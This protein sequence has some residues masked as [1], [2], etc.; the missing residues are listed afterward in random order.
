MKHKIRKTATILIGC[1]LI[2]G[3]GTA[4]SASSGETAP[5]LSLNED[6]AVAE[7]IGLWERGRDEST[8]LSGEISRGQF[9]KLVVQALDLA[10]RR[11]FP[12]DRPFSDVSGDSLE[13]WFINRAYKEGLVSGY[14]DGTFRPERP[15]L[16]QE[17]AVI[18]AKA[19]SLPGKEAEFS[20]VS[21]NTVF[22]PFIGAVT[23][24]GVLE[25]ESPGR[26]GF[27]KTVTG[28]QAVILA[29]RVYNA[30]PFELMEATIPQMQAAMETGKL[31]SEQLVKMYLD[32]IAAYDQQ[33]PK[34]N[35]MLA[36]N[37]HALETARQLD[38]ERKKN[39]P[40]GPL[41]G[42][43]IVLKDNFNTKDM[44]TT[45]GSAVLRGFV[46]PDDAEV[47]KRL[48]EAGAV[49]LGKTNLHEFALSGTTVSSLGGQTKNPYDLTRTPGGS[50][51]GTGAAVA[52]NFAAAGTGTDTVNSIRSPSSANSLVGIRPTKGLVSLDGVIPVSFTQDAAGPIARTVE[53]ASILLEVMAGPSF[54]G[55][56]AGRW[57]NHL[58]PLGL[59][60]KR[61]GVL[62]NFFGNGPEHVPV[63][64]VL[65]QN[66]VELQK[67]GAVVIPVTIP[68]LDANQLISD[69]DVQRFELRPSL[70]RYFASL[71][72]KAPVKSLKEWLSTGKYDKSIEGILKAAASYDT[73]LAEPEYQR[74]LAGIE[75]LR[76]KVLKVMDDN[77]LDVLVYPHQKRLVVPIGQSQVDRNGILGALTGFPAIT[78]PGGFSEPSATAP[79]GVPVGIEF[80]GR[81]HSE[82]VL[83]DIG[84]SFEQLTFHRRPPASTPPLQ[85]K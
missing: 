10:G 49:I 38:A 20:D 52:S 70:D 79:I 14:P 30:L 53:D 43:P 76:Q 33:G 2:M 4:W 37:S 83:L 54:S 62:Q 3:S 85:R 60:G 82:S 77:H 80:L 16:K 48:R 21:G 24:R 8:F 9:V 41:H 42:I 55:Q 31:T 32:R 58:N 65:Q 29:L 44:P 35:A 26:F 46:P 19:L 13:G 28:R 11:D 45:G 23:E 47:V 69:Y 72:P 6:L 73:P 74:R 57:V 61:I 25:P 75:Q 18:L 67:A 64:R 40:R 81:P 12:A 1:S 59:R 50:S 68:G 17:A 63:N 39:G 66:I 51:G 7:R 22:S 71:G 36:I 78:V 34:I 15:I 5:G 27:G 84:Y 56:H